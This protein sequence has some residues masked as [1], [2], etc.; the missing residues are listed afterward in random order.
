MQN[1]EFDANIRHVP[2]LEPP[3]T[4]DDQTDFIPYIGNGIFGLE[5]Q[6]NGHLNV[7]SG[8]ALTLPLYF[9]PIVSVSTKMREFKEATV[10]EYTTGIVHRFDTHTFFGDKNA[11]RYLISANI[12]YLPDFNV[13]PITFSSPINIMP[14]GICHLFSSRRF[15]S[16]T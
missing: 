14:I 12:I 5:I 3:T 11:S 4:D 8:R 2:P 16:P 1:D 13:S 9:R 10:V 6:E 15:K 7:K